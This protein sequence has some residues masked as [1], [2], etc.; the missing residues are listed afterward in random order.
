MDLSGEAYSAQNGAPNPPISINGSDQAADTV[1]NYATKFKDGGYGVFYF[2]GLEEASAL[3]KRV[4]TDPRATVTKEEYISMMTKIVFG[5]DT[6]LTKEG[7][8][9]RKDW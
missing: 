2:Y 3:L 4:S 8:D 6:V 5:Q 1:K 7:G 9:F